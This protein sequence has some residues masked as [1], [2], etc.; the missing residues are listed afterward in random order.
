MSF[1]KSKYRNLMLV[2]FVGLIILAI[3]LWPRVFTASYEPENILPEACR[4]YPSEDNYAQY[5][6]TCGPF[7]AA[8]TVRA[9]TQNEVDSWEFAERMKGQIGEAGTHPLGVKGGLIA[10]DVSI[11]VPGLNAMSNE[12][13]IEF[14]QER[15]SAGS[16]I[17]LLGEYEDI[18]Y[19]HYLT[20]LGFDKGKDEFYIYDSLYYKLNTTHTY[21]SNGD[22]P[23][24]KNF[25][26]AELLDF[27]GRG[28]V[29]GFY[30]WF[31]IV[32]SQK[33]R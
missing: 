16:A 20:V 30:E 24:N 1:W 32:G 21:D 9:L 22:L 6:T 14:L 10:N 27:W 5:G 8:G 3:Y 11:E 18:H 13:R 33:E 28:G 7:S 26:S 31:A 25:S 4:D 2:G 29:M 15:L 12:E 19:Q 17:I 23:G